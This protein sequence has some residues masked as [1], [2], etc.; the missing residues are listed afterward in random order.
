MP[1][2]HFVKKA[3]VAKAKHGIKKGDSYYWWK[4]RMKGS[5]SGVMHYSKTQPRPSQLTMS[6]FYGAVYAAQE[7]VEDADYS[8]PSEMADVLRAAAQE[9]R[10]AGELC[11]EKFNN[12][13]EGLQQ[14]D[15]GQLLESRRDACETLADALETAADDTESV[16]S[17]VDDDDA[18]DGD[19]AKIERKTELVNDILAGI[20][21][22]FE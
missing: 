16:D 15:T 7:S 13:P 19:E 18:F 20:D 10:E 14:G 3:R 11:D 5:K 9:I 6:E 2:V 12:M 1:R 17:D 4:T 8:V 22:T 21:W